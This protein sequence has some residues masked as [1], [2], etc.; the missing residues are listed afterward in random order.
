[1][2]NLNVIIFEHTNTCEIRAG[3]NCI[4]TIRYV[5]SAYFNETSGILTLLNKQD[6]EISQI[7]VLDAK[8]IRLLTKTV[9]K[10]NFINKP[11]EVITN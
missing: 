10:F 2:E 7:H 5:S 6:Q 3:N 1:M 11:E 4:S 9:S 8:N